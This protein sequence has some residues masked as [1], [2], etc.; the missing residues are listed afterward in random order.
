MGRP[1]APALPVLQHLVVPHVGAVVAKSVVVYCWHDTAT[2][3]GKKST[4]TAIAMPLENFCLSPVQPAC[5]KTSDAKRF[6]V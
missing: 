6:V 2:R 5:R 4:F 3:F 1:M